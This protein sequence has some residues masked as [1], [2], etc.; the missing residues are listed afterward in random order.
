MKGI[1]LNILKTAQVLRTF[2]KKE[3]KQTRTIV[4]LSH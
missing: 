3:T 4:D 2:L 1:C